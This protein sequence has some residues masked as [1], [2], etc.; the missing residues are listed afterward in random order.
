M[1]NY[2]NEA[3]EYLM[4]G[5][6]IR[7]EWAL[8]AYDAEERARMAYDDDFYADYPEDAHSPDPDDVDD[9]GNAWCYGC[10]QYGC[11]V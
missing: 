4:D 10:D 1:T 5:A 8:D 7:T 11:V 6:A 2:Q 9:D 3:G